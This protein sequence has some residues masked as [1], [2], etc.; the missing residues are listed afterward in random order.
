MPE[1]FIVFYVI[2]V[3]SSNFIILVISV[4]LIFFSNLELLADLLQKFILTEFNLF[5]LFFCTVQVSAL[6]NKAF[7]NIY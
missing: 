6:Y 4:F 3:D 1:T 2:V 7:S 5:K